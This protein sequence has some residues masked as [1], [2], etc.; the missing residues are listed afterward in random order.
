MRPIHFGPQSLQLLRS[1]KG[2]GGWSLHA[3][4]ALPREIASGEEPPLLT[5]TA[6]Q[7]GDGEW[8]RP[9]RA[10]RY[11]AFMVLKVKDKRRWQEHLR[12]MAMQKREEDD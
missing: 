11:Q 7:D 3:P 6:Q 10:D 4:W 8:D 5:G 1:D 9:D 12:W 2:D